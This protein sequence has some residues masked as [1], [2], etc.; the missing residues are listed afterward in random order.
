MRKYPPVSGLLRRCTNPYTFA[1]SGISIEADTLV[2]VPVYSI[3]HDAEY[4]PDPERFD[5]DRFAPA[6]IHTRPHEAML[7][8][9]VGPRNCIGL[10]FGMMQARVGLVTL[11]KN[12]EIK[13]CSRSIVPLT[14]SKTNIILTPESE[15]FLEFN[16]L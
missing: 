2:F 9:G 5:P 15:L 1:E 3:H 4:Y 6:L 16:K 11:L 7:S 10:R 13:T 14:F 12:F 8:F